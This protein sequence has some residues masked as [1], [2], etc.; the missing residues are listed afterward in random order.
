MLVNRVGAVFVARN[1][2]GALIDAGSILIS[3]VFAPK[4]EIRGL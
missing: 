2:V 4:V 3:E 1:D